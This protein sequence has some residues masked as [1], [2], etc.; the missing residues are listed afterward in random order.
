MEIFD[1]GVIGGGVIG[2]SVLFDLTSAGYNCVLLEKNEHL[3]SESSAGNSGMLHTGYDA[4][5]GSVEL[6]CIKRSLTKIVKVFE[7]LGVPFRQNGSTMVAWEDHQVQELFNIQEESKRKGYSNVHILTASELFQSEP[8]LNRSAKGAL[9][10]PGEMILDPWLASISFAHHARLNGAK[11]RTSCEVLSCKRE[12]FDAWSLHTTHG[13]IHCRVVVN[14]A[15]L[16]GDL[17]DKMA[18][19]QD[20]SI[21]PRKGQFIVFGSKT[22]NLINSSIIPIPS[23]T[24]KG[25]ITFKTV[26][27]NIITG[28]TAEDVPS[29]SI[30]R[31]EPL[32]RERLMESACNTVPSLMDYNIIGEYTGVRP[33]TQYKDYQIRSHQDR[34]WITVGGI[35][36]TGVSA[37]LG[38]SSHVCDLVHD[39]GLDP[40]RGPSS[41]IERIN[42]TILPGKAAIHDECVYHMT[43]PIAKYGTSKNSML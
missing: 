29:R 39:L 36:S 25:I 14:C 1:V 43:H 12:L 11:I 33:A 27:D 24:S 15:G 7:K 2:C 3:V 6:T 22:S 20:F 21:A 16:Q 23:T 4:P 42:W 8:Y 10:I 38:I 19:Y 26:Y 35:R 34:K 41:H 28:P 18:G 32:I 30:P 40:S 37:C 31:P 13:D 5:L 17:V 9:W